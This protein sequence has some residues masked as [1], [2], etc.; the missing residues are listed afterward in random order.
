MRVS[1]VRKWAKEQLVCDHDWLAVANTKRGEWFCESVE[2]QG[3][4]IVLAMAFYLWPAI[5]EG[6][7]KPERRCEKRRTFRVDVAEQE[8][9]GHE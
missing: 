9:C 5:E 2:T 6:S 3:T 4:T 1:D 8:D 7:N